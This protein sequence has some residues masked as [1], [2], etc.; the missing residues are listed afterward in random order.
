[1]EKPEEISIK[2]AYLFIGLSKRRALCALWAWVCNLK[3]VSLVKGFKKQGSILQ[4]RSTRITHRGERLYKETVAPGRASTHLK[5]VP[6]V[7]VPSARSFH[8]HQWH[9]RPHRVFAPVSPGWAPWP[10]LLAACPGLQAPYLA[11]LYAAAHPGLWSIFPCE[12]M[13]LLSANSS[14]ALQV[15]NR[16][17]GEAIRGRRDCV[18]CSL[19]ASLWVLNLVF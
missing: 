14:P 18:L 7:L 1:M 12:Q 13:G 2:P 15:P 16:G 4:A 19:D 10:C 9:S 3:H 5:A 17:E 8:L 6:F 11:L